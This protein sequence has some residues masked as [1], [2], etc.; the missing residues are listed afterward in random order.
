MTNSSSAHSGLSKDPHEPHV[1]MERYSK[2]ETDEAF[3]MALNQVLANVDLLL[4]R[5]AVSRTAQLPIIY[6]V[7]APR[8]GTTLMSQVLSR[9]LPIGYVDNLIARFWQRPSVGVRLSQSLLGEAKREAIDFKSTHGVTHGIEGPHEFG[10]FWRAWLGLDSAKSHKLASEELVNIDFLGL[11]NALE[12]E[13]LGQFGAPVVFKNVICG[14]QAGLLTQV[15]PASLFIWIK[16]NPEDV[17][18]S[19]LKCRFERYGRYDAW[20]SLKPSTYDEL[21]KISSPVLQVFRQVADCANEFEREFS[22]P[23]INYLHVD[24]ADLIRD[25]SQVLECVCNAV[26]VLGFEIAPLVAEMPKF[27]ELQPTLLP[28]E[29]ETDLRKLFPPTD[30]HSH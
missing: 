13:I 8:S 3:F 21:E 27:R 26:K 2:N 19:I 10:Y 9:Y 4:S 1:R 30:Q 29:F 20:W 5:D 24:Y 28:E 22:K 11:K 23:G 14:F 25:P 16:R 18:R 7:G 17:V 6:I 12:N 15:H